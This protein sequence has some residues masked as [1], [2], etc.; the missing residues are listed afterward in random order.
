MYKV[1]RFA[2][3]CLPLSSHSFPSDRTTS[4]SASN[5]A[6]T[7]RFRSWTYTCAS[8]FVYTSP[9]AVIT[10]VG[11]LDLRKVPTSS[12]LNSFF[13]QHVHWC[14]WIDYGFSLLWSFRS[15]RPHCP[16]FARRAKR[17]FISIFEF[18]NTFRQDPCYSAGASFFLVARSCGL[19]SNLEVH[20]LRSWGSNFWI[21]PR[22]GPFLSRIFIWCQVPLENLTAC[23]D[24]NCP[25]SS[26]GAILRY[27]TQLYRLLQKSNWSFSTTFI[28]LF[29]GL[30]INLS[31]SYHESG[32]DHPQKPKT[33]MKRRMK[34]RKMRPQSSMGTGEK[35]LQPLNTG[36]ATFYAPGEVLV[37]PGTHLKETSSDNS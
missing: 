25:F 33:K 22:D 20:G 14:S 34:E 6:I 18:V 9:L 26:Q 31:L 16:G 5:C 10:T 13:A 32:A 19:S 4:V 37:M 29:T 28:R 12:E 23:F 24:P 1:V 15:G 3:H 2:K 11:F 35:C 30:T 17:S 21:T 8:S 27:T 7:N 36:T